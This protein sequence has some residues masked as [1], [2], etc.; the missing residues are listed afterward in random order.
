MISRKSRKPDRQPGSRPNRVYPACVY[1]T[2]S[3]F[4]SDNLQHQASHEP[5]VSHDFGIYPCVPMVDLVFLQHFRKLCEIFILEAG[6]ALAR[7]S[8]HIV[9][10]IV[11]GQEKRAISSSPSSSSSEGSCND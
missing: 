9:F 3:Y 1:R 7:G 6:P 10:L 4:G 2:Q 5:S 11:C 8:E